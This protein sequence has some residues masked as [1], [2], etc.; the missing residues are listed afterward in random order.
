MSLFSKI[1]HP[2]PSQNHGL[3]FFYYGLSDEIVQARRGAILETTKGQLIDAAIQHIAK[4][5][6]MNQSSRVI[7]GSESNDLGKIEEAGYHVEKV[8]EGLKLRQKLYEPTPEE[9]QTDFHATL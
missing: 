7:F 6:L 5:S 3:R 4:P 8:S 1:D 9:A 2:V